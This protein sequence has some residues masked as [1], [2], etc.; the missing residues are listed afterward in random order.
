[1]NTRSIFES[2]RITYGVLDSIRFTA[3]D[4]S[5]TAIDVARELGFAEYFIRNLDA[6]RKRR[7]TIGFPR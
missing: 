6:P 7:D 4:T 1:M 5:R 3:R 2:Y